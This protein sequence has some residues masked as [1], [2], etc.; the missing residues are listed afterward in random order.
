MNPYCADVKLFHEKFQLSVPPK[1]TYLADD[2]HKF[3]VAFLREEY[4]EYVDSY[5]DL[6]LGT[7]LDSL[8]DLVYIACGT[9]LMHGYTPEQTVK[10]TEKHSGT[11]AFVGR[12]FSTHNEPFK[13]RPGLLS[14]GQH[15]LFCEFIEDAISSYEFFHLNRLQ[16]GVEVSLSSVYLNCMA[17]AVAMGLSLECWTELWDDVQRANMSKE[18]VLRAEDSKRGSTWDVRKPT[19]W[20]PPH[21]EEILA[22]YL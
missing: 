9:A 12:V 17:C 14:K 10:F 1:F 13:S 21:T 19:G 16:N 18:R 11:G 15:T 8:I 20:I 6:D 22:K 7:A 3:R 5:R 2:L 4:Q